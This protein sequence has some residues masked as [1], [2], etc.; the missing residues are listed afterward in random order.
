MVRIAQVGLGYWGKNLLRNFLALDE[1]VVTHLCDN[2]ENV[3]AGFAKR[4]P[5][6]TTTTR[7]E[8]VLSA[9]D[10]DAVVI[11]TDTP[12]HFPVALSALQAGKHVFVE[13]PMAQTSL[14][15]EALVREA[16]ARNARLVD[17]SFVF[18]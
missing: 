14:E 3:L 9:E 10:V 18:M 17:E 6:I 5:G 16:D 11:A 13:K 12:Q 7:V 15:A 8:T 1:C 4:H 2:D